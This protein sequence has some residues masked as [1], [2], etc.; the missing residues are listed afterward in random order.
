M[1][2]RLH[3]LARF[4][5]TPPVWGATYRDLKKELTVKFQPTPPVWGATS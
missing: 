2:V 5:P 4:Q 3:R 1:E